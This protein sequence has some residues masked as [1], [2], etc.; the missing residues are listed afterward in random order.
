MV[1]NRGWGHSSYCQTQ[2][3]VVSSMP[4]ELRFV[5]QNV[6]MLVLLG[7]EGHRG[8]SGHFWVNFVLVLGSFG[9]LLQYWIHEIFAKYL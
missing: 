9:G 3:K 4:V 1:L 2:L 5:V 7:F 6:A 8:S